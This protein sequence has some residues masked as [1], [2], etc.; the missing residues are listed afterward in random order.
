VDVV[1][2]ESLV[3]KLTTS[4]ELEVDGAWARRHGS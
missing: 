3:L 1:P 4:G 2:M